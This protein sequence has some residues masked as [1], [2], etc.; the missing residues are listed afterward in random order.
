[1][2]SLKLKFFLQLLCNIP[3]N[4]VQFFIQNMVFFTERHVYKH[5]RVTLTIRHLWYN[6][7]L[8][9]KVS[10]HELWRDIITAFRSQ[11]YWDNVYH[12]LR[13]LAQIMADQ[14][15]FETR[16]IMRSSQE[17]NFNKTSPSTHYRSFRRRG[18]P[19]NH[20][21]WYWQPNKNNQETEHTNNIK[22]NTT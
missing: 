17:Y 5:S 19:V 11:D 1:M 12:K 3:F 22:S 6:E 15:F 7:K 10:T 2:P 20:L 8:Q 4:P 18:F 13:V 21:H 14:A 16:S 9:S